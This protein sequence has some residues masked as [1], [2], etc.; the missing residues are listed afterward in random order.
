MM[1][2]KEKRLTAILELVSR[3]SIRSQENL[4]V[5][6]QKRGFG[7]TQA[8]LSRDIKRL[9]LVKLPDA[10]GDYLYTVSGEKNLPEEN[11]YPKAAGKKGNPDFL[12][13][14]FSNNLVVIKTRPGYAMGI[15]FDI[16][17]R[18]SHVILGTIAG[19]D[20]ILVI[21]REGFDRNQIVAALRESN[22]H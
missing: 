15:A 20:T 12:S 16:D 3:H 6:L 22:I 5:L 11:G 19:D 2:K 21:P 17:N 1:T 10:K 4:L 18:M 14:D 9:K 8:T 13:I 7:I